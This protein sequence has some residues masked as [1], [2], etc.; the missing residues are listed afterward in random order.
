M[1]GYILLIMLLIGAIWIFYVF[2]CSKGAIASTTASPQKDFNSLNFQQIF[3]LLKGVK[4]GKENLNSAKDQVLIT[5]RLIEITYYEHNVSDED[6]AKGQRLIEALI[7]DIEQSLQSRPDKLEEVREA[8]QYHLSRVKYIG[9]GSLGWK[10][11]APGVEESDILEIIIEPSSGPLIPNFLVT[12]QDTWAKVKPGVLRAL[13][14]DRRRKDEINAVLILSGLLSGYDL[15]AWNV[16]TGEERE[17][18]L[19]VSKD[20]DSA[21]EVLVNYNLLPKFSA[22]IPLASTLEK[23]FLELMVITGV[24]HPPEVRFLFGIGLKSKG[25]IQIAK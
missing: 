15:V 19:N 6:R 17:A 9:Y 2:V 18:L 1:I 20:Y 24:G 13:I 22:S 14:I 5:K 8:F 25:K 21:R 10:I 12:Q 3:D 7:S 11:S 4:E 16:I 23:D